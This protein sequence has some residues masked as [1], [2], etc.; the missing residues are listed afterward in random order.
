MECRGRTNI[1]A[2]V[3]SIKCSE[4]D[5]T[6][7]YKN[8][9]HKVRAPEGSMSVARSVTPAP[10]ETD[11]NLTHERKYGVGKAGQDMRREIKS[12]ARPILVQLPKSGDTKG[13]NS[14]GLLPDRFVGI[15]VS[16]E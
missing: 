11:E 2:G 12:A 3:N 7:C 4:A 16:F 8:D 10:V 15:P 1:L 14:E 6:Q 5:S 13:H 9:F